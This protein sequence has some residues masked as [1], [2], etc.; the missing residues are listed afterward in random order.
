MSVNLTPS[1][2][3]ENGKIYGASLDDI[4]YE[5]PFNTWNGYTEE[6]KTAIKAQHPKIHIINVPDA[7]GYISADMLTRLWVN[8]SPTAS[9]AAQTITLS[10]DDYDLLMITW[11]YGTGSPYEVSPTIGEKGQSLYLVNGGLS[12]VVSYV[13][14]TSLSVAQGY[15]V[16]TV[17]NTRCVPI[18][19]YGI[20]KNI[21]LKISA[22]ASDVNTSADHC[23]LS[24]G[25]TSV[26]DK[27]TNIDNKL[28]Y[29]DEYS[30]TEHIVG[31]WINGKT[32]YEKTINCGNL[33]SSTSK[34]VA[35]N[36]SNFS[37]MLEYKG[38]A[39]K[40]GSQLPIPW[41]SSANCISVQNNNTNLIIATDAD[42]S[43]YKAYVTVRYLKTT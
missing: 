14:D 3:V 27:F 12:R 20:K 15:N 26:E 42:F 39:Y 9:F 29:F 36:I 17:D 23:M 41:A 25:V 35:H 21:S 2:L 8:P 18:A 4:P 32:I 24:D 7:T 6:Q 40:S 22:I 33:P 5:I 10:S 11:I 38:I 16:N 13:S 19:I 43:S 1:V 28:I 34:N 31:K 30:E 37:M